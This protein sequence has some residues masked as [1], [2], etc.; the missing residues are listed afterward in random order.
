VASRSTT[1]R[2]RSA[3]DVTIAAKIIAIARSGA[4]TLKMPKTTQLDKQWSELMY[5]CE[6]ESTCRKE[7][8]HPKLLKL[9]ANQIADLAGQM[10]FSPR[11]IETRE[12]RAEREGPHIL[13]VGTELGAGT[14]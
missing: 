2:T 11:Q 8:N 3:A 10:G 6:K 1:S 9:I 5:L 7:G 13:R 4:A 12:F 14:D